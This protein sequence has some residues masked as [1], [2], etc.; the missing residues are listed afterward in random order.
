ME[1]SVD[2]MRLLEAYKTI[3]KCEDKGQVVP[4][5][6]YILAIIEHAAQREEEGLRDRERRAV[7]TKEERDAEDRAKERQ[8]Y[9][10]PFAEEAYAKLKAEIA[11]RD[12]EYRALAERGECAC[13]EE[14]LHE[15]GEVFY[16]LDPH[17]FRCPLH[18][19]V[20]S[21][22]TCSSPDEKTAYRRLVVRTLFEESK[23]LAARAEA[24]AAGAP[25]DWP[26]EDENRIEAQ[27]AIS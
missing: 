21:C 7:M 8:A 25:I 5:A 16:Y 9:R 1:L 22:V 19:S 17:P 27:E 12:R 23:R 14:E 26:E 18:H 24:F 20:E 4:E 15:D 6:N 2:E 3:V 13:P 11:D 10:S